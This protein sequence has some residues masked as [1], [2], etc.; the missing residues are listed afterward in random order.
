MGDIVFNFTYHGT[1][2]VQLR[3]DSESCQDS[4]AI[5]IGMSPPSFPADPKRGLVAFWVD[6]VC[7][8]DM[9]RDLSVASRSIAFGVYVD[10][11]AKVILHHYDAVGITIR[12]HLV[13]NARVGIGNLEFRVCRKGHSRSGGP[14][15]FTR[16]SY[17][18]HA[19]VCAYMNHKIGQ[20][21]RLAPH[22]EQLI[23][24]LSNYS[25]NH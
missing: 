4:F 6:V 11:I 25:S 12:F 23:R 17:G 15:P 21:Y 20:T 9:Q 8:L 24:H 1:K 7:G 2:A 10:A 18:A 5:A 14:H 3:I 13:V 19:R 16:G 22:L